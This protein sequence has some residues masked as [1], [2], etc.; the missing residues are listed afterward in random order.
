MLRFRP[1][2][3]LERAWRFVA[4]MMCRERCLMGHRY[5]QW[6]D[7]GAKWM[8]TVVNRRSPCNCRWW[9]PGAAVI[10]SLVLMTVGLFLLFGP[11][12][13]IDRGK[14][15][16]MKAVI[17]TGSE[18]SEE[19]VVQRADCDRLVTALQPARYDWFP[20]QWRRLAVVRVESTNDE[21]VTIDIFDTREVSAAFAVNRVYYR[22]GCENDVWAALSRILET[23]RNA[24]ET[25]TGRRKGETKGIGETQ[26]GDINIESQR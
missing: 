25:G 10:A 20:C 24:G 16:T 12:N 3:F 2:G 6:T 9:S 13:P 15:R 21:Q 18:R 11:R 7:H 8:G 1:G 17:W 4:F 5:L 22:G 23:A 26:R 14:I 19:I